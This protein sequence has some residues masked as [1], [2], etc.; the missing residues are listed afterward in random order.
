MSIS[1]GLPLV[2]LL[3]SG[4]T[5]QDKVE[6]CK[7][8]YDRLS[9]LPHQK[10][11]IDSDSALEDRD[12]RRYA[13]CQVSFVSHV[14]LLGSEVELPSFRPLEGDELYDSGWREDLDYLADGPGSGS[15]GISRDGITCI[16]RW[17]RHAWL[18][19]TGE[20]KQSDRVEMTVD[21]LNRKL[22]L[23]RQAP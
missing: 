7:A 23:A 21:C 5:A 9:L 13:G 20:I 11:E 18:E 17:N 4:F 16:I 19:S 6:S 2:W 8:F 15:Y 12:G 1:L 14:D 3:L 22:P 10:L